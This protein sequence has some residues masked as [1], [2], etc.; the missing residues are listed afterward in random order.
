MTGGIE[1]DENNVIVGGAPIFRRFFGQPAKNLGN[2]LRKH[3]D[4]EF[5]RLT[6]GRAGTSPPR[7]RAS[8]SHSPLPEATHTYTWGNN[9][10]RATLKGRACR[11]LLKGRMRSVMV[12]FEN[13]QR[14]I[15]SI[16][17]LR[18]RR[19]DGRRDEDDQAV[20]A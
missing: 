3:G 8:G 2:W 18:E 10:K 17:A 9:P 11:I 4:V 12:E 15:V 13:G 6:E 14:E 1:L 16:R 19:T 5:Q 7:Q 20:D